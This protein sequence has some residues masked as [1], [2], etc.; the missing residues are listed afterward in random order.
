MAKYKISYHTVDYPDDTT[1]IG[2]Y[3]ADNNSSALYHALRMKK[4]QE[5]M[6]TYS[7]Q[8][9]DYVLYLYKVNPKTG[10]FN[11]IAIISQS[12]KHVDKLDILWSSGHNP[13]KK[14]RR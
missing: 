1:D 2:E 14:G 6:D 7:F 11:R 3:V 4:T 5:I 9:N 13:M 8:A 12:G 10:R